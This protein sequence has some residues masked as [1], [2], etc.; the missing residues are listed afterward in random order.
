MLTIWTAP[1]TTCDCCGGEF[2]G[3]LYDASV[4]MPAEPRPIWGTVCGGCFKAY[5]GR[6]GLGRGQRYDLGT[7]PDDPQRK[8][9]IKTAG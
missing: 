4:R 7:L 8:A 5:G 3:T 1:V 9:W 6:L 2:D